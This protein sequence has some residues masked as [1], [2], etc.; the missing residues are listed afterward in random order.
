M[1]NT[2]RRTLIPQLMLPHFE[3][4]DIKRRNGRRNCLWNSLLLFAEELEGGVCVLLL[5]GVDDGDFGG[6]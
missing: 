5:F 6:V 2:I 1:T 4:W 3:R